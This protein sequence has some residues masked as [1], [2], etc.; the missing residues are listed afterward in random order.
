MLFCRRSF[1]HGG[2]LIRNNFS[3][4]RGQ[5]LELVKSKDFNFIYEQNYRRCFLFVQSYI[6]QELA[7]EDIVAEALVKYW[8]LLSQGKTEV[9]DALL[10]TILKNKALDYLK[11]QAVHRNAVESLANIENRELALRIATLEACDPEEIF[12]AEIRTIIEQTLRTLP[13]QTRK[14]FEMSRFDK[15]PVKE[16][17]RTTG[18]TVKGVEYHITKSLKVLRVALKD[19]LPFFYFLFG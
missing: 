1:L 7:A 18:L 9:S 2:F 13:E 4:F 12:S 5:I 10:L 19:Y 3:I 15:L 8:K 14:V 11:H 6:H 16:I 17:A